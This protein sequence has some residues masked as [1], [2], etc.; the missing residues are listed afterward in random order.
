MIETSHR[1]LLLVDD[2]EDDELL[3]IDAL[4]SS[5]VR[6]GI[7]VVRDGAEALDWL[8]GSGLHADRDTSL[9]P[10]LVLLDLKLPKLNGLEVLAR[11]RSDNRTRYIPTIVVS[12]STQLDDIASSYRNGANSYVRKAVDFEQYSHSMHSLCEFWLKHN[13]VCR[14]PESA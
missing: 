1:A 5:G 2:N 8:F 6:Q 13:Q 9:M 7:F 11:M 3:T 10:D 12:S 14:L 4:R